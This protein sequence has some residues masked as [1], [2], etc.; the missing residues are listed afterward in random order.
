MENTMEI[1][2][3]G[4]KREI[5]E[6]VRDV[7]P[8]RLSDKSY[9][10]GNSGDSITWMNS[11]TALGRVNDLGLSGSFLVEFKFTELELRN[12]LSQ[13]V[14]SEP[15]AAVRL[16]SEMQAEAI[17]AL[18]KRNDEGPDLPVPR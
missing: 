15:E 11:L 4:W 14:L 13:F 18:T 5:V 10:C 16:L 8:V 1:E 7:I 12:W 6:H 2:F 3:R 9:T 17:I